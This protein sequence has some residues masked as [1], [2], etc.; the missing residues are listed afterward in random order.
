MAI[1]RAKNLEWAIAVMQEK[2]KEMEGRVTDAL[3]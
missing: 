2:L 3:C 1:N